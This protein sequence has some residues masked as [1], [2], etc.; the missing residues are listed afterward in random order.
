MKINKNKY[1]AQ[2]EDWIQLR[3]RIKDILL[4]KRSIGTATQ[5]LMYLIQDEIV[6][7]KKE[8]MK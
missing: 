7:S 8:G 4:N 2:G 6:K 5:A 3:S 1:A